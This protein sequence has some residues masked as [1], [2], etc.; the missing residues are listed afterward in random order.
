MGKYSLRPGQ[1]QPGDCRECAAGKRGTAWASTS[2]S[3]G[4]TPCLKADVEYQDQAGQPRCK[5][6]KCP[7]GT[8]SNY[9]TL[10]A[11]VKP[12]CTSCPPGQYTNANLNTQC[13]PCRTGEIAPF[14]GMAKCEACPVNQTTLGQGATA[15]VCDAHRYRRWL[16]ASSDGSTSST[17]TSSPSVATANASC[18]VCPPR[19]MRCD[20]AG[21]TVFNLQVDGGFWR[22]SNQTAKLMVC[23]VA[24]ACKGGNSTGHYC[25]EGHEGPLCA[26]C[27]PTFFRWVAKE[28]CERCPEELGW[29]VMRSVVLL[30]LLLVLLLLFLRFNRKAPDGVMRPLINAWQMLQVILMSNREWPPFITAIHN[31]FVSSV[32]LDIVSLAAPTCLGIPMSFYGRFGAM[33]LVTAA[34]LALPWLPALRFKLIRGDD[35][36]RKSR[37]ERA[38]DD[39]SRDTF[40]I[41]LLMHPTLSGQAFHL[42]RCEDIVTPDGSEMI[43]YL[44][45]DYSI[46]CYTS[47]WVGM[48]IVALFVLVLF[49]FGMPFL[50]WAI[51]WK[52]RRQ[53]SIIE[54]GIIFREKEDMFEA[55]DWVPPRTTHRNLSKNRSFSRRILQRIKSGSGRFMRSAS[56]RIAN[57]SRN[58]SSLRSNSAG[59]LRS[60]GDGERRRAADAPGLVGA[61]SAGKASLLARLLMWCRRNTRKR[62]RGAAGAAAA[63]TAAAATAGHDEESKGEGRD[64][65]PLTDAQIMKDTIARAATYHKETVA[66][67]GM[68][69]VPYRVGAYYFE[70]VQ[71]IFKLLLWMALVFFQNG[72]QFQYATLLLICFVQIAVHAKFEPFSSSDKNFLQY[73]GLGA[74]GVAAFA[75]LV[76]NYLDIRE[77]EATQ[78]MDNVYLRTAQARKEA[79]GMVI[80]VVFGV[81]VAAY[82]VIWLWIIRHHVVQKR[83][84]YKRKAT[85]AKEKFDRLKSR[86]SSR[87]SHSSGMATA[88][89]AAKWKQKAQASRQSSHGSRGRA[90]SWEEQG[91]DKKGL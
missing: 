77:R 72:D 36:K 18:P 7:A 91:K 53:I 1:T 75:G 65:V 4:C 3:S 39:C 45:A 47:E 88:T 60:G 46:R 68:L 82:V 34:L 85:V 6:A 31:Y 79:F 25:I 21:R 26:V 52:R 90:D 73:C 33:V 50:F 86:V 27:A 24:E 87:L 48:L 12:P 44:M 54:A 32:N 20:K 69:F 11:T 40:L 59:H 37:W 13:A 51:L 71:M 19:G 78:R 70:S 63:A 2:E 22:G 56:G 57:Q 42:F 67:Y 8:F 66:L 28:K 15:C 61:R 80:D 35:P 58:Q 29:R 89:A 81:I 62:S 55:D 9:D 76:M 30:L 74:T 83:L 38:I 84:K 49:S 16:T 41:V 5:S 14:P 23:P 43:P 64:V 17:T 10:T